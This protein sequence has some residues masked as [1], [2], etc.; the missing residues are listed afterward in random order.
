MSRKVILAFDNV[1]NTRTLRPKVAATDKRQSVSDQR[2]SARAAAGAQGGPR[3]PGAN[4][5]HSRTGNPPQP[6][7]A[8]FPILFPC[9][10]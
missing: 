1:H 6:Y 3:G 2:G 8:R 7:T 5:R 9:F 10:L 4:A